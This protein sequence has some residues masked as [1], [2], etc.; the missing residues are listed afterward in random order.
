[1]LLSFKTGVSLRV[2]VILNWTRICTCRTSTVS[3]LCVK[4]ISESCPTLCSHI[5]CMTNLLWV[6][7]TCE[8][9]KIKSLTGL[10]AWKQKITHILTGS[11][12]HPARGGEASK[13]WWC[14]ERAT[15]TSSQVQPSASQWQPLLLY[16]NLYFCT[17]AEGISFYFSPV[18]IT[19]D[20]L[21]FITS[22]EISRL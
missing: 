13:D 7:Q 19:T 16:N 6:S 3:A 8:K 17:E 21:N 1:M 11:C 9:N 15:S 10:Q 18:T 5:S 14:P 20:Q 12:G 4:L 22:P 2:M